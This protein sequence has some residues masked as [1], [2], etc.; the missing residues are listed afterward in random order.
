MYIFYFKNRLIYLQ[1]RLLAFHTLISVD[2]QQKPSLFWGI[3]VSQRNIFYKFE[4][5]FLRINN[6]LILG[7][8]QCG[9]GI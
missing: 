6:S 7:V 8:S 3:F 5:I 9:K 2:N 4:N 1:K